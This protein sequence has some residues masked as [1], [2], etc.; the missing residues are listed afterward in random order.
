MR[1]VGRPK[2]DVKQLTTIYLDVNAIK[3]LEQNHVNRSQ[4]FSQVALLTFADPIRLQLSELR[5]RQAKLEVE[6]AA[7][8]S[9][10]QLVEAKRVEAERIRQEV[11][12]ERF[13]DAWY[14]RKL[15]LEGRAHSRRGL[16]A[17][18]HLDVDYERYMADKRSGRVSDS[19]SLELFLP[20][21]PMI[22]D[23]RARASAKL[24]FAA[25]LR[26]QAEVQA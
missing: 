3:L 5:E 23:D 4:F 12:V 15:L 11:E 13:V 16:F 17:A 21:S 14:F 20:Y 6:I 22:R 18:Y 7:V 19:S 25:E 26:L 1:K 24:Q 10:I 8:E 2:G 9:Q